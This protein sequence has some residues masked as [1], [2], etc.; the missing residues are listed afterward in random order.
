MD[1]PLKLSFAAVEG[2]FGLVPEAV[3]A[4]GVALA[5]PFN[6]VNN[7]FNGSISSPAVRQPAF[8]NNFGFDVDQ[9]AMTVAAGATEVVVD[10][11]SSQDRFRLG[12]VSLV[13]PL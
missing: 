12:S 9:F 5:N 1:R 10:I 13:L 2:D 3:S 4:N 11:S 6:A 8:V 7:P